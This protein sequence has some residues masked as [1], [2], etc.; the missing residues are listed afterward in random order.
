MTTDE[1]I[2][3]RMIAAHWRHAA[4]AKTERKREQHLK[5]V[6]QYT[7]AFPNLYSDGPSDY[8]RECAARGRRI[9]AAEAERA[10]TWNLPTDEKRNLR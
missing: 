2:A 9:H 1:E 6:Q 4:R 7:E 10:R 8:L 5:A 3:K